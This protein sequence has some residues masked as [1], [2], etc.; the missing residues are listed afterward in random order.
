MFISTVLGLVL[1]IASLLLIST[2]KWWGLFGYI[3][4][5]QYMQND[6]WKIVF[7]LLIGSAIMGLTYI[8]FK[9]RAY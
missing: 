1:P 3:T 4:P 7:M 2:D 6:D 8:V 9:R 5:Y